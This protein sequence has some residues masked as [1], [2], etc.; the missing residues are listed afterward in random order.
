ME[1]LKLELMPRVYSV[2]E[3]LDLEKEKRIANSKTHSQIGVSYFDHALGGIYANDVLLIGAKSGV[4]KTELATLI[5]LEN[6]KAGQRVIYFALEAEEQEIIRRIQFKYISKYFF[7]NIK[8]FDSKIKLRYQD[9]YYNKLHGKIREAEKYAVNEITKLEGK[10]KT[11]YRTS[12]NYTA[13]DFRK[14]FFALQ[15]DADMFIVDHV[16]YFDSDEPNENKA[17]KETMKRIRDCALLGNKPIALV[18]HM[19]KSDSKQKLLIPELDDFHGSS[20][21]AKIA[22][23]AIAIAPAF[24]IKPIG[25]Q[26]PTYMKVLKNRV[27][28]DSERYTALGYFDISSNTYDKEYSV[29][30][31]KGSTFEE[32]ERPPMWADK[33]RIH[34][35]FGKVVAFEE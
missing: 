14:H 29:G 32:L 1:E 16:H 26:Y 13:D 4:G 12:S 8:N 28:S 27:G 33:K 34:N 15:D 2:N 20:D 30:M 22:T 7:D 21:L 31:I 6:A 17:L 35:E 3:S 25:T 19:R 9:W 18:A 11:I 5:A 23:K 10:L 24:D